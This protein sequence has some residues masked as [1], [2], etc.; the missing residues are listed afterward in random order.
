MSEPAAPATAVARPAKRLSASRERTI[1]RAVY[2]ILAE[3]GY[4]G[5]HY[6]AVATRAR[7]S[8]A[9]LYRHWPTKAELV[10][11]AMSLRP[12]EDLQVPDTGTLRGD[13]LAYLHSL[14]EWMSGE[15]GAVISGL[16]VT[17]R[18]DAELAALLRPL[19]IPAVPPVRAVCQRAERRGELALDRDV[20]FIDELCAPALFMRHAL[21]G[22][23]L[24]A[25][26]VEYLVDDVA[27]PLLV[28]VTP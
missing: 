16:F 4:Q 18:K 22:L 21:L 25:D 24:D 3:S 2:E 17:M 13:L 14:A 7:T 15:P 1:L 23:P 6:E 20:R 5:L 12:A 10:S 19:L 9:T 28:R 27:M 8:K 26:F 11:T